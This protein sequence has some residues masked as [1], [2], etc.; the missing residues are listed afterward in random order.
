LKAFRI[1]P[2]DRRRR[3][4]CGLGHRAQAP[5]RRPVS[6]TSSSPICRGIPGRG[7]SKKGVRA[8]LPSIRR[9]L[10]PVLGLSNA[11]T[12]VLFSA[13]SPTITTLLARCASPRAR[14]SRQRETFKLAPLASP[15][16]IQAPSCPSPILRESTPA[17]MSSRS[18]LRP[19]FRARSAS[20]QL[21]ATRKPIKASPP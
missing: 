7:S 21:P 6:A 4:A 2:M 3:E 16:S 15:N 12:Y 9:H 13:P 11:K 17:E 18:A 14:F 19:I 8:E 1:D 5:I 20:D 10:P